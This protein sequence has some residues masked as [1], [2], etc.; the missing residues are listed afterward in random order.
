VV[1]TSRRQIKTRARGPVFRGVNPAAATTA[2]IFAVIRWAAAEY[3][4]GPKRPYE[5][6]FKN[7][8][9]PPIGRRK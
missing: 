4:I 2:G 3:E 9:A 6:L 5:Q 1:L 8:C 7:S